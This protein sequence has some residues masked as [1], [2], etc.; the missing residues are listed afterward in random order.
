MIKGDLTGKITDHKKGNNIKKTN[1]LFKVTTVSQLA[2]SGGSPGN[3]MK[4]I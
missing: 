1:L 2:N 3:V 4:D